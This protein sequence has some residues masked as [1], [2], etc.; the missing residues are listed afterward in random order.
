MNST[1]NHNVFTAKHN[2]IFLLWPKNHFLILRITLLIFRRPNAV[3]SWLFWW[4]FLVTS[5]FLLVVFAS[6]R[7]TF[8]Y[9]LN[10]AWKGVWDSQG[11]PLR[12]V[13]YL[14]PFYFINWFQFLILWKQFDAKVAS[15]CLKTLH[16][17]LNL[18][19]SLFQREHSCHASNN[20]KNNIDH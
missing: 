18:L 11:F 13:K 1:A 14:L 10:A 8:S 19:C 17:L 6:L 12:Q 3:Y 4:Y 7:N 15:S 20:N 9:S 2:Q 5:R 16:F